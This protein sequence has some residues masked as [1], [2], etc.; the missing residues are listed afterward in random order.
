MDSGRSVVRRQLARVRSA[1]EWLVIRLIVTVVWPFRSTRRLLMLAWLVGF[2]A[3]GQ[4]SVA[5]ADIITGPGTPDGAALNPFEEVP[6]SNYSLLITLS[7]SHHGVPYVEQTMWNLVGAVSNVLMYLTLSLIKGAIVCMQWMLQLNLYRENQ[8]QIDSAVLGL[9]NQIFW[10]LFATTLVIAGAT[11]YARKNREGGGSI[12]NDFVW[13]IAASTLAVTFAGIPGSERQYTPEQQKAC[14]EMG[15]CPVINSFGPSALLGD[16]DDLRR[17]LATGVIKGYSDNSAVSASSAGFPDVAYSNASGGSS[18]V[19]LGRGEVDAVRKLADSMWNVYAVTPWCYSQFNSLTACANKAVG[20]I[21][22]GAHFLRQD[23]VYRTRIEFLNANPD[24]GGDAGPTPQCPSEWTDVPGQAVSAGQ[25]DWI[26]GQSFGR[27]GTVVLLTFVTI[28]LALLLF[29]LVMYGVMAIVGFL[30]L[31]LVGLLFLLGWMIPGRMRQIGVRWFETLLASLIQSVIITAVLGAV[32]VLGAILNTAIPTYGYFVVVLLNFAVFLA[33]FK[34]RGHFETITQMGSPTSSSPISQY[35]A[36]KAISGATRLGQATAALPGRVLGGGRRA[37]G[38][39]ASYVRETQ[40]ARAA[41]TA[42]QLAPLRPKE[43]SRG[44]RQNTTAA[45]YGAGA[46]TTASR[47]ASTSGGV[48]GGVGG[49]SRRE[50][51]LAAATSAA[52]AGTGGDTAS[53]LGG[54]SAVTVNRDA[55]GGFSTGSSGPGSGRVGS[56]PGPRPMSRFEPRVS[57]RPLRPSASPQ[58]SGSAPTSMSGAGS[59]GPVGSNGGTRRPGRLAPGASSPQAGIAPIRSEN[60][61]PASPA[62]GTTGQAAPQTEHR[63]DTYRPSR[64]ITPPNNRSAGAGAMTPTPPTAA[65]RSGESSTP[66]PRTLGATPPPSS[67]PAAPRN[68][69]RQQPPPP[70]RGGP[71]TGQGNGPRPGSTGPFRSQPP[72]PPRGKHSRGDEGGEQS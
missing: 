55:A 51:S 48:N 24:D 6:V 72:Q 14:Q 27:L 9:A 37:V 52:A 16:L 49:S 30:L 33:A 15:E 10:P 2:F 29:A 23:D 45:R 58:T 59:A 46:L 44:D 43:R 65:P 57:L 67:P 26:R 32:M 60:P 36:M 22:E 34:I 47:G 12:V 8:N 63:S 42:S 56:G 71:A 39:A 68:T 25:C 62:P 11:M 7:D 31:I 61:K 1:A 50:V 5:S 64:S 19:T 66:G 17:L 69:G 4:A 53:T 21:G 13:I 35:A 20:G 18:S 28:P 54:V 40:A 41:Q 70:G 3:V 38:G